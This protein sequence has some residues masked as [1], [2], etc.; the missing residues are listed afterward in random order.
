[1]NMPGFTAEDCLFRRDVGYY[2]RPDPDQ[3]RSGSLQP[4]LIPPDFRFPP[5]SP[6]TTL[7]PV[8]SGGCHLELSIDEYGRRTV[9]YVCEPFVCVWPGHPKR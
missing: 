5:P 3:I 4:A 2:L 6:L 9:D 8:C 7:G 1:M